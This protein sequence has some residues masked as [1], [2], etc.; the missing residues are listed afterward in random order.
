VP[1]NIFTDLDDQPRFINPTNGAAGNVDIGPYE[2]QSITTGMA[3]LL[4]EDALIFFPNPSKDRLEI[5]TS[6]EIIKGELQLVSNSG[7][8]V[9]TIQMEKSFNR[10]SLSLSEYPAGIYYLHLKANGKHAVKKFLKR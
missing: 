9:S 5:I 3:D 4:P 7:V 1:E 2:V 6:D 10:Y 8:V